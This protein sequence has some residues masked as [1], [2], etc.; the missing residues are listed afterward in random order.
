[1]KPLNRGHHARPYM[2]LG[3]AAASLICPSRSVL[4]Q[5]HR[6]RCTRVR[7]SVDAEVVETLA[8]Y[9][10]YIWDQCFAMEQRLRID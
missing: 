7:E 8:A 3:V 5:L 10:V 6:S 4:R 1:M 9:D 2:F